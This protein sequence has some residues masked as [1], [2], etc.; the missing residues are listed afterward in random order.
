MNSVLKPGAAF[1]YFAA[2]GFVLS[3]FCTGI[4]SVKKLLWE[5]LLQDELN[6]MQEVLQNV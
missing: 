5:I 2:P 3:F 1:V 6:R 4:A